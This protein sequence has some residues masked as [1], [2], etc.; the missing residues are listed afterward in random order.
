MIF[1]KG[2]APLIAEKLA[3]II[4]KYA[5]FPVSLSAGNSPVE[6]ERPTLARCRVIA[7]IYFQSHGAVKMVTP[8]LE[9]HLEI[10][11]RHDKREMLVPLAHNAKLATAN[12]CEFIR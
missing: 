10:P 4:V 2:L 5:L 1:F 9:I 8:N 11:D 12:S 7:E 6:A 3:G